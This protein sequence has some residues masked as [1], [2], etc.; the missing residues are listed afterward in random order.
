VTARRFKDLGVSAAKEMPELEPARIEVR[1]PRAPELRAPVQESLIEE[2][3]GTI[4]K[5]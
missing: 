4:G 5:P 1:E 3:A 2:V